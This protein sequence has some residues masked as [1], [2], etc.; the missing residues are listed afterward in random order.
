ML[1]GDRE[2]YKNSPPVPVPAPVPAVGSGTPVPPN[3]PTLSQWLTASLGRAWASRPSPS[4]ALSLSNLSAARSRSRQYHLRRQRAPDGHP[5]SRLASSRTITSPRSGGA[6]HNHFGSVP[7]RVKHDR[8]ASVSK[9]STS[10]TRAQKLL[11][12]AAWAPILSSR[13]RGLGRHPCSSQGRHAPSMACNRPPLGRGVV[14]QA[15]AR[16]RV[17]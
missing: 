16:R 4:T 3:R 5:A 9:L 10:C 14:F 8:T 11:P 6:P 13:I 2:W 1:D 12:A 17:W 15:A 7:L